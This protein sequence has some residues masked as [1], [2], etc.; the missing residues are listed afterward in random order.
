MVLNEIVRGAAGA[1][2]AEGGQSL[3]GQVPGPCAT[4]E[5]L[6]VAVVSIMEEYFSLKNW[7]LVTV[8]EEMDRDRQDQQVR[9]CSSLQLVFC[10]L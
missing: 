7:H 4:Q 1:V 8:S 5:D 2:V 10:P 6:K 9:M 3:D